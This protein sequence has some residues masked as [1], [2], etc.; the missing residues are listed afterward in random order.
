MRRTVEQYEVILNTRESSKCV[1]F[2]LYEMSS[3]NKR[4]WRNGLSLYDACKIC[5]G[6][7]CSKWDRCVMVRNLAFQQIQTA[8]RNLAWYNRGFHKGLLLKCCFNDHKTIEMNNI[9]CFQQ[10][11]ENKE[12]LKTHLV[13]TLVIFKSELQWNKK[14]KHSGIKYDS[15]INREIQLC[16]L[17][18]GGCS[19]WT[20]TSDSQ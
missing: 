12:I 19:M 7:V 11:K 20:F 9:K 5:D 8:W 14:R 13:T 1:L 15:K 3:W 16:P 18:D 2:T 10:K 6:S 4:K 17:E